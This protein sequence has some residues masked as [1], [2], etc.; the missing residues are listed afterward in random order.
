MERLSTGNDRLDTVLG[1]GLVLNSIT[2]LVG[3][4]GRGKTLLASGHGRGPPRSVEKGL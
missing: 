3:V 4:P 2:L 1:G